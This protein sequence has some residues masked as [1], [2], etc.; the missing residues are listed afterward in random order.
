MHTNPRLQYRRIPTTRTRE[1]AN[2]YSSQHESVH[3]LAPRPSGRNHSAQRERNRPE[4]ACDCDPL[5]N[6]LV[7][8]ASM[9]G[10]RAIQFF[11]ALVDF[12]GF[13]QG[14]M[15]GYTKRPQLRRTPRVIESGSERGV[16]ESGRRVPPEGAVAVTCQPL[17]RCSTS[18]SFAYP[19][20]APRALGCATGR[21]LHRRGD[22]LTLPLISH[23]APLPRFQEPRVR[24]GHA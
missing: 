24:P 23:H 22:P 15:A 20:R 1:S 6:G 10:E 2:G 5:A 21:S 4:H 18:I 19:S 14:G 13:R 16:V 3:P 9:A 7:S 11:E 8:I 12:H 17:M